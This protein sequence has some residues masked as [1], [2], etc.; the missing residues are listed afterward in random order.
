MKYPVKELRINTSL[1]P[2]I[3]KDDFDIND[4]TTKLS[5]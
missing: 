1:I 4:I 3:Y 5:K 2:K